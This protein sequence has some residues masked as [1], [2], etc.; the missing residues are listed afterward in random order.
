M[1]PNPG[2]CAHAVSAPLLFALGLLGLALPGCQSHA[3]LPSP[4]SA[5]STVLHRDAGACDVVLLHAA[6][7]AGMGK[8]HLDAPDADGRT[9]LSLAARGGCLAAVSTLVHAGAEVERSD[10]AGWTPLHY[11]ASQRH[12]DVVD[13]LLAHGADQERKTKAGETALALA[14]V[15]SREQFGPVADRH[16]TEMVLLS[17]HPREKIG[18]SAKAPVKP[19]NRPKKKKKPAAKTAAIP[20][21]SA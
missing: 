1:K 6:Q 20:R 18:S 4:S 15:G 13:Y 17:G 5:D 21:P 9:P 11:A 16:T 14:L 7:V 10:N 8:A 2:A 3:A 19:V 12:A